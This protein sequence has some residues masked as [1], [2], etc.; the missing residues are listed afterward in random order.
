MVVCVE[1]ETASVGDD[2]KM[3]KFGKIKGPRTQKPNKDQNQ[4]AAGEI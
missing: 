4:Q 1:A 3:S 2:V